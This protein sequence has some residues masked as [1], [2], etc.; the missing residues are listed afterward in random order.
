GARRPMTPTQPPELSGAR[1]VNAAAGRPTFVEEQSL[2]LVREADLPDD[3]LA[4]TLD[5]YST[6]ADYHELAQYPHTQPMKERVNE[7][8]VQHIAAT[9]ARVVL[10]VGVADGHRLA[11]ICAAVAAAHGTRPEMYGVELSDQMIERAR[12]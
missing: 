5:C 10:D 9:R 3:W 6:E 7:F 4:T 2:A 12:G 1:F 11:R 8:A